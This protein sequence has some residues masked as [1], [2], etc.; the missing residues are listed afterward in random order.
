MGLPEWPELPKVPDQQDLLHLLIETVALE[1][2]ALAA[3]VNAEAEKVQ[4]MVMK[5]IAAPLTADE[6][7]KINESVRGVILAAGDKEDKLLQKL[8]FLMA[9]KEEDKDKKDKKKR[10]KPRHGDE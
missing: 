9:A 1:E 7:V 4:E 3:L 10:R 8:R 6:A 5:G 2:L